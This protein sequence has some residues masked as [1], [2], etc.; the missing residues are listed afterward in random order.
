MDE[1]VVRCIERLVN[2]GEDTDRCFYHLT[3]RAHHAGYMEPA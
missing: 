3:T 2:P 1:A